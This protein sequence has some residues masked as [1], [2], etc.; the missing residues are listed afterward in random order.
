MADASYERQHI[1]THAAGYINAAGTTRIT[2]GCL[3]TRISSGH[4][5]LLLDADSGVVDGESF[6]VVQPKQA[7]DSRAT[8]V[9]DLS[10]VEKRIRVFLT[11]AES[12]ADS[13][14]EVILFKTVTR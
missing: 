13:D 4:Y 11:T 6:T 12:L 5:G 14:I 3:M 7:A 2:F 8:I 9:E 10:S 1:V